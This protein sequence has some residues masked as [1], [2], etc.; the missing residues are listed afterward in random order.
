MLTWEVLLLVSPH[1]TWVSELREPQI[2]T[3]C[4]PHVESG[5]EGAAVPPDGFSG[6][7]QRGKGV[8]LTDASELGVRVEAEYWGRLCHGWS[9]RISK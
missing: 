2:I 8:V 1:P 9:M 5:L 4:K 3:P 7:A 6:Q